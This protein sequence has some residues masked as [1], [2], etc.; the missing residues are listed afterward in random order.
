MFCHGQSIQT[1][2]ADGGGKHPPSRMSEQPY[3][4]LSPLAILNF[5]LHHLPKGVSD[6]VR[7]APE[8]LK[9]LTEFFVRGQ[10][11]NTTAVPSRQFHLA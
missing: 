10:L 5:K 3:A 1:G 9:S 7:F 8:S 2:V 11:M 4:I 6:L